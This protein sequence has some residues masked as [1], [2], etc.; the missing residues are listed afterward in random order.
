MNWN[1]K[2]R[3]AADKDKRLYRILN[4]LARLQGVR[5]SGCPGVRVS[6]CPGVRVSALADDFN[7]SQRQVQR[8]LNAL[9]TAG[10]PLECV[11]EGR[12][13]VWKMI[14]T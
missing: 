14:K 13:M 8:D 4:I 2:R 1:F 6:G 12:E 3:P 5:V 7:V 10:F 11:W 9:S